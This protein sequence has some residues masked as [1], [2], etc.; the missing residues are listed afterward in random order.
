VSRRFQLALVFL[1][2]CNNHA[3]AQLGSELPAGVW[4]C[5]IISPRGVTEQ[6]ALLRFMADAPVA[7]ASAV[8]GTVLAWREL[9]DAR[10]DG[11]SV[12][13]SDPGT[14]QRF[15]GLF[16]GESITG[17]WRTAQS[18]GE[19][20]CAPVD[21]PAM[22]VA[23]P[24]STKAKR[25]PFPHPLRLATPRYPYQ[26]VRAGLEGRVVSCFKVDATGKLFD[27]RILEATDPIFRQPT[28]EALERSDFRPWS[29]GED[30]P[31]RP[32]CRTYTFQLE[33]D[34]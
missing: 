27:P 15:E 5:L 11:R 28:L 30:Q 24:R 6:T 20:W 21:A 22:R 8:D 12:L 4:H 18:V 19:W 34:Y 23:N 31:P 14:K 9:S 26:A 16:D 33:P 25:F 32:A 13:F 17:L 2:A 10:Y 1:L 7:T 29:N 3:L